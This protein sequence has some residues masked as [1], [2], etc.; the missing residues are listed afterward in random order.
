MKNLLLLF[1]LLALTTNTNAQKKKKNELNIFSAGIGLGLFQSDKNVIRSDYSGLN[2]I[3]DFTVYY[4]KNLFSTSLS[5]GTNVQL[6]FGTKSCYNELA[7]QYGRS[8]DVTKIFSIE[9]F[10]GIG[11]FSQT[12]NS[13]EIQSGS[14]FS[15]PLKLNLSFKI[16]DELSFA[17]CNTYSI[18]N[19]N[20]LFSS[21][22]TVKYQP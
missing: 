14:S 4:K 13:Y 6:L 10:A 8:L 17:V 15:T 20:N 12:S 18:N 19:I 3:A 22:I 21:N 7:F 2:F 1:F 11:Q 5:S 9:C 16:I